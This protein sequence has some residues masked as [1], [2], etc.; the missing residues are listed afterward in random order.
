MTTAVRS[1]FRVLMTGLCAAAIGLMPAVARAQ[2]LTGR[3]P[4]QETPIA[5]VNAQ[6]HPVSSAPIESGYVLFDKGKISGVGTMKDQPVFIATTRVIDAKGKRVYPGLISAYTQ[7][8]L[9]EIGAVRASRDFNEA[10]EVSPEVFASVSVN[11]DSWLMPV[12]RS[13]GVLAFGVFPQ[14]GVI[15]G[16]ASTIAADGWTSEDMTLRADS[17]L[18]V[19][20]PL[21]RVIRAPWMD[22]SD[23]EQTKRMREGQERVKETFRA[24]RAYLA[25][26]DADPARVALD[27]RWEAMRAALTP[28]PNQHTTFVE[29]QEHDQIGAAL[30]LGDEFKLKLVIVGGRDAPMLSAELKERGVGVIVNSP[31]LMPRRDD[32][33]IDESYTIAGRLSAAGVRVAIASGEETPHE[34]NLPYAAA[35]CVAHGMPRDAALRAITLDAATLLGVGERLGSIEVGKDATL[36]VVD[37]DPLEVGAVTH[38]AFINGRSVDLSNKQRALAEKYR[39]KYRQQPVVPAAGTPGATPSATPSATPGTA[40]PRP[41]PASPGR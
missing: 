2:D 14:G 16:R 29:A 6:V 4:K 22:L 25:A 12:A 9:T 21:M 10:G 13:N 41:V 27:V 3:A 17:G 7:M 19:A 23:E 37:D 34:R 35:L 5:I 32:S 39:E 24:A 8:G 28:G 26:R 36:I 15:P 1:T 11:P 18:V 20:W 30:A 33:P 31:L 40:A 38:M